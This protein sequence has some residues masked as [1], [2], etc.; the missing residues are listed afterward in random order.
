LD[1]LF[2]VKTGKEQE[3]KVEKPKNVSILDLQR[4]NNIGTDSMLDSYC[5][6]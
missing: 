4:A 6:S 5:A 1:A 3:E 2:Y